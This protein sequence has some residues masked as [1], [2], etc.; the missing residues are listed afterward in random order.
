MK[1]PSDIDIEECKEE[2]FNE[3]QKNLQDGKHSPTVDLDKLLE[4][5]ADLQLPLM[6]ESKCI[7]KAA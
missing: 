7:K 2:P 6:L 1:A 4:P 5:F 3:P